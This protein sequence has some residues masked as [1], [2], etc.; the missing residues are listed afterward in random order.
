MMK[1]AVLNVAEAIGN[2]PIVKLNRLSAGLKANIYCV[3]IFES[4]GS[5]K[6]R[7]ALNIINEAEKRGGPQTWR[8]HC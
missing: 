6:D 3:G 2:T 1:G 4:G 7:I 8:Y 5:V